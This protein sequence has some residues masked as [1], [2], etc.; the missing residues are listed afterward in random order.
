MLYVRVPAFKLF[1]PLNDKLPLPFGPP[2]DMY[3]GRDPEYACP[4]KVRVDTDANEGLYVTAEN[5]AHTV[6]E[7][8]GK[9]RF[10]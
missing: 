7:C 2:F 10:G 1:P 4:D 9:K 8:R 3:V 6:F 5:L